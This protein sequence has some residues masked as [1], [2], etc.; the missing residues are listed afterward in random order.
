MELE[1]FEERVVI[2]LANEIP[3][4]EANAIA[5]RHWWDMVRDAEKAGGRKRG[6]G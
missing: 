5:F 4:D 3:W 1:A 6:R 2:C